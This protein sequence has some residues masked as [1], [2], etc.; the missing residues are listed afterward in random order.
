MNENDNYES[1][2]SESKVAFEE[3]TLAEED[4]NVDSVILRKFELLQKL[5][6]SGYSTTWLATN[7]S[8]R[9]LT[10]VKKLFQACRNGRDARRTYRE[11]MYLRAMEGHDN[12]VIL[13]RC[14]IVKNIFQKNHSDIDVYLELGYMDSDL[15]N[16]LHFNS[17][18]KVKLEEKHRSYI[19]YQLLKGIRP[20]F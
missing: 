7:K 13:K 18:N 11:I 3:I 15:Y 6:K 12:I 19:I 8:N 17:E 2:S 1:L 10:V 20:F 16:L 9:R 4:E 14:F 5:S